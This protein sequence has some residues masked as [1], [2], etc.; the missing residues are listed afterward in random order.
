MAFEQTTV[1]LVFIF[2]RLLRGLVF[3]LIIVPRLDLN[4]DDGIVME[5]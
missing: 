1:Y 2:V 5:K 3:R 4:I